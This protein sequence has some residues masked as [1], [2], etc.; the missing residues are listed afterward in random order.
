[1][2]SIQTHKI[3]KYVFFE[4]VFQNISKHS[5]NICNC[6]NSFAIILL[7]SLTIGIRSWCASGYTGDTC[8]DEC[9]ANSFHTCSGIGHAA[10]LIPSCN[11]NST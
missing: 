1:M 5:L 2:S 3:P 10:Q 7:Y 8:D 6:L 9:T 11:S 4:H